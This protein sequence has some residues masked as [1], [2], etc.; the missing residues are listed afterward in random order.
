MTAN[1]EQ[2]A[3]EVARSLATLNLEALRSAWGE[4]MGSPA[5]PLRSP[6]H[7]RR[8]LAWRLQAERL[9]GLEP[10]TRRLLSLSGAAASTPALPVGARVSREWRG[11]AHQVEVTTEGLLYR[12]QRFRSLSEV[13]RAITGVRWNGPR[14][15]GLRGDGA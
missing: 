10:E 5:P 15:F 9:G 1:T 6:D 3:A 12:G 11:E 8:L 7:L 13:A 2:G 4:H 14:F